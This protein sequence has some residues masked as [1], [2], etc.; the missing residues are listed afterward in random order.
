[1]DLHFSFSSRFQV[2]LSD[3]LRHPEGRESTCSMCFANWRSQSITY[4]FFY[5]KF[6]RHAAK[7][8]RCAF[9]LLRKVRERGRRR[10][11]GKGK[12]AHTAVSGRHRSNRIHFDV[13]GAA[14]SGLSARRSEVASANGVRLQVKGTNRLDA[15]SVYVAVYSVLRSRIV[16]ENVEAAGSE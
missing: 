14:G 3:K 13:N 6:R 2:V 5:Q 4:R 1:M 7:V 8:G 11:F 16:E 10:P 9:G 15:G 12:A